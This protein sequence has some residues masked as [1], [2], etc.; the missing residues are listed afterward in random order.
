MENYSE[1]SVGACYIPAHIMVRDDLSMSEKV[2]YGRVLA[3]SNNKG[4]CYATNTYLGEQVGLKSGT[5]SDIV[6]KLVSLDLVRREIIRDDLGKIQHR[7]LFPFWIAGETQSDVDRNGQETHSGKNRNGVIE[8]G[9][10]QQ[11]TPE[12]TGRYYRYTKEY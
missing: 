10:A 7:K 5:V 9:H 1:E 2:I 12:K 3:L 6:S 11:P 4:Y 8:V